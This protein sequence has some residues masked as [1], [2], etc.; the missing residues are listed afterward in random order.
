MHSYSEA[1]FGNQSDTNYLREILIRKGFCFKLT[2]TAFIPGGS[3]M[4]V[5][6]QTL[7]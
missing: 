3:F 1:I 4:T 6:K 5:L 7:R 2:P